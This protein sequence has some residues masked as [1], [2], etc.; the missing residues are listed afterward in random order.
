M[1]NGLLTGVNW[2]HLGQ[3][4]MG[5]ADVQSSVLKLLFYTRAGDDV[6]PGIYC[7]PQYVTKNDDQ[8]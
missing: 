6:D 7:S 4:A 8:V 2:W 1:T 3:Y 5:W